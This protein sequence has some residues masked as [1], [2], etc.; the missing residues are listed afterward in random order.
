MI[1][2]PAMASYMEYSTEI[3]GIYMKYVAPE[4]I[5]VYSID[6][7]FMDVTNY[8]PTY[9]ISPHDLAMRIILDVLK[10]TGIIAT[11]GIGTNLYL[12]KIAMDIMAKHIPADENG[13]RIAQLDEMSYRHQLWGHQP[14]TDFWRVGPGY[15]KRLAAYGMVTMGDVA[16]CSEKNEELL[17]RLFGKQAELLIDHAWGIEPCQISDIKAYVPENNSLGSGQ[18]LQ[19][20]YDFAKARIV[21]Q[22]MAE[23][24]SLEL[25]SKGLITNQLVMTVGYDIENIQNPDKRRHYGGEVVVDRYGRQIPKHSHGSWNLDVY[26]ASTKRIRQGAERLFDSIVNKELL[27]RRMNLTA[28]HVIREKDRPQPKQEIEQ[29]DLFGLAQEQE[30]QQA[31]DLAQ[32]EKERR[33]QEATIAIKKKFGK[34]ALLKGT[35]LQEGATAKERNRQIGGHRA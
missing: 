30:R 1:A 34:N 4:D 24:L 32:E 17:Y 28:N 10:N 7:V 12:A 26:T 29:L 25:V 35:N 31:K 2:P 3:Y 14:I 9:K 5:V 19:S 16:L 27:I 11:A 18:V 13:V 6:E 20:P 23:G 22:E 8:L 15:A 21:M 33:L